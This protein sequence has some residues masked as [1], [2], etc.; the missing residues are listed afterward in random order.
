MRRATLG[1][2]GLLA[3]SSMCIGVRTP[4][5]AAPELVL[6][7]EK[8]A[9]ALDEDGREPDFR[10]SR[11]AHADIDRLRGFVPQLEAHCAR[12]PRDA[13]ALVALARLR[14][15]QIQYETVGA[16][17]GAPAIHADQMGLDPVLPLL[18]SA[19]VLAPRFAPAWFWKARLIGQASFYHRD[20][21]VET[22]A[23]IQPDNDRALPPAARAVELAPD[24]PI[25]RELY[26]S[27]LKATGR[28]DEAYRTHPL[29][30]R[31]WRAANR[32]GTLA[33]LEEQFDLIPL[34]AGAVLLGSSDLLGSAKADSG[35]ADRR[36]IRTRRYAVPNSAGELEQHFATA[37]PGFAWKL[38]TPE[39]LAGGLFGAMIAPALSDTTNG[40]VRMFYAALQWRSENGRQDLRLP[41]GV[42]PDDG[43]RP[44]DGVALLATELTGPA[45]GTR[46]GALEAIRTD[47]YCLLTVANMRTLPR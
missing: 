33:G 21:R 17:T 20:H 10:H 39:D 42:G 19:L 24:Q 30:D 9:T 34:P 4:L 8:L 1:L 29:V 22:L 46:T 26:E 3:A 44:W 25:Y 35:T 28:T 47:P 37:W 45:G 31:P 14:S 15:S 32:S 16:A 36:V 23:M 5:A 40:R 12:H 41:W 11:D 7:A 27:L 2:V 18:D 43:V 6:R 38:V 13:R